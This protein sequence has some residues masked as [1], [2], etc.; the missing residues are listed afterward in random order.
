M[1]F[2]QKV[3]QEAEKELHD[4]FDSLNKLHQHEKKLQNKKKS[5]DDE[6]DTFKQRKTAAKLLQ[7]QGSQPRGS[8][9]LKRDKE[10]KNFF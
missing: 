2:S 4:K 7:F 6:V 1:D 10:K 8:Q 9:T 5:L 3:S